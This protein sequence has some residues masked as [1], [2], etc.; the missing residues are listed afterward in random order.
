P[1]GQG[2]SPWPADGGRPEM[3]S[4]EANR[5]LTFGL[6]VSI[7]I[8]QV[9]VYP[10]FAAVSPERFIPWHAGYTRTSTWIVALLMLGQEVLLGWLLVVGDAPPRLKP[11]GCLGDACLSP[12][13]FA[14][15][16]SVR[17]QDED[18]SSAVVSLFIG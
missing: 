2:G 17:A 13:T 12:T 1:D 10:A 18:C 3:T 11:C 16:G 7:G 9:I 4:V 8:V 14:P 6:V 15:K 5:L